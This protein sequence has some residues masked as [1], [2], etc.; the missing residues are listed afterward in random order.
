MQKSCKQKP[1][2]DQNVDQPAVRNDR[3]MTIVQQHF[4]EVLPADEDEG[5]SR[6]ACSL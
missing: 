3:E 4:P 2:N 1:N 5:Q 6:S